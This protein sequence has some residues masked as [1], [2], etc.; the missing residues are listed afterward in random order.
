MAADGAIAC[1]QTR[2]LMSIKSY[3][4]ALMAALLV[5]LAGGQLL[6]AGYLKTQLQ[7][8]LQQSTIDLSQRLVRQV[9]EDV[10]IAAPPSG[11]KV[12]KPG[13]Q[14][15][16]TLSGGYA[17]RF[18]FDE[19]PDTD[20]AKAT[21]SQPVAERHVEIRL[22]NEEASQQHDVRVFT[23]QQYRQRLLSA[24]STVHIEPVKDG[25]ARVEIIKQSVQPGA[26]RVTQPASRHNSLE[27]Y[28]QRLWWL[29][30]GSALV[31]LLA[32][33]LL[34]HH[35]SRPLSRLASGYRQLGRGELGVQLTPEGVKELKQS[36]E[37][38]NR[39]SRQLKSLNEQA[40]QLQQQQH[41]AEIGDVS[42]GL[43]HSLRNPLHTLGLLADQQLQGDEEQRIQ[44]HRQIRQ[45]IEHIDRHIQSLLTLTSQGVNRNQPQPLRVLLDD[46]ALELAMSTTAPPLSVECEPGD[47]TLIGDGAELRSVLHSLIVNAVEASQAKQ[48]VRIIA[49]CQ[50]D[51]AVIEIVDQGCGISDA[52]RPQLFQPHISTKPEGTG[53]GLYISQRLIS[54]HYHGTLSLDDNP[55]GGTIA[56]LTIPLG[57]HSD[58]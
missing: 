6:F 3:L 13:E 1:R 5:L 49:R 53:M 41:L 34:S 39:M 10:E 22:D 8:D 57:A 28:W 30:I 55:V 27:T 58:P 51:R 32:A 43:A 56:R 25:S 12:A 44:T 48:P 31:A 33:Y 40:E 26:L 19:S 42:R 14:R 4:F 2:G 11:E 24:L 17:Y 37:D 9:I 18:H 52:I 46:I 54:L 23:G 29:F 7:N 15:L 35:F 38:F 47:L 20:N 45:K 50:D 36:I 16:I 21:P